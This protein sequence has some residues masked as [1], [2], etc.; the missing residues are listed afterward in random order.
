MHIKQRKNKKWKTLFKKLQAFFCVCFW[1]FV[2]DQEGAASQS[3]WRS[4]GTGVGGQRS[5]AE[6]SAA[7]REMR[8]KRRG[9]CGVR[10]TSVAQSE[11]QREGG[12]S[13]L[14]KTWRQTQ[15][16][17]TR[18]N[19]KNDTDHRQP[20]NKEEKEK[21]QS[22]WEFGKNV[23]FFLFKKSRQKRTTSRIY[24]KQS[25]ASKST[26]RSRSRVVKGINL[27]GVECQ[28][29]TTTQVY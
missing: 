26:N 11:T 17:Q 10:W 3:Q 22:V 1:H 13:S 8:M 12:K 5:Q 9:G 25:S 6:S 27:W 29:D 28:W 4:E 19:M 14:V 18:D 20:N 24:T 7:S 2:C 23:F 21:E 15:K 16:Q